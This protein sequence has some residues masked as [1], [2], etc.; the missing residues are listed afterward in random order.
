MRLFYGVQGTGNG[1]ISRARA[2]SRHLASAGVETQYLFSG[3]RRDQYFDMQPFGDWWD[4]GGLSFITERGRVRPLQ[5]LLGN[6]IWHLCRDICQLDLGR[7]DLVISDFEPITAWAAR[8][9]GIPCITLG[10]QYAFDHPIPIEGDSWMSRGIMKYFTPGTQRLGLHWHHFDQPILPPIIDVSEQALPIKDNQVLVYL[11]F[12][13][14]DEVIPLLQ[15]FAQQK[16]VYYG[17]FA[18]ASEAGNVSLRPL[19]ATAF[20]H[21]LAQSR[22]VICNAGFELASEALHLGKSLL[23]KPL[24]GQMEQLS[25]ALALEQLGL[26]IRMESLSARV[27]GRWLQQAPLPDCHYPDVAAAIV[28]WLLQADRPPLEHLSKQLWQQ[29]KVATWQPD[30]PP[31]AVGI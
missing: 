17:Q 26:G 15:Q 14:A 13:S 3:R 18:E 19:S 12:E 2:M 11:G 24:Q 20:K 31:A 22:G 4:R 6:N 9:L 8:R 28:D 27:I 5:T 10:H 25:N 16:F 7:Y 21:D 29:A 1:H 23:V 30:H